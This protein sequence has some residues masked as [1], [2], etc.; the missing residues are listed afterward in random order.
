MSDEEGRRQSRAERRAEKRRREREMRVS[1]K[2][3]VN[4][5]RNAILKRLSRGSGKGKKRRK[6]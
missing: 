4:A 1:G 3:F 2:G 5:V 6:Q